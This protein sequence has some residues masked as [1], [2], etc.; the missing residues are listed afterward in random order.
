MCDRTPL[1]HSEAKS[2]LFNLLKRTFELLDLS[3]HLTE[4]D[5]LNKFLIEREQNETYPRFLSRKSC[6]LNYNIQSDLDKYLHRLST[7]CRLTKS[8]LR[9]LNAV[10][11]TSPSDYVV[12][13]D[14]IYDLIQLFQS[15]INKF[16]PADRM[17]NKRYHSQRQIH[18][19]HTIQ[20]FV[21]HPETAD[22][23]NNSH[24]TLPSNEIFLSFEK[25]SQLF[26]LLLRQLYGVHIVRNSDILQPIVINIIRL[27]VSITNQFKENLSSNHF[28]IEQ[29][30]KDSLE[31][32]EDEF[33]RLAD[34][35]RDE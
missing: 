23:Q 2:I 34:L 27:L 30:R 33:Y 1:F 25:I 14:Q 22:N 18:D 7:S 32:D 9:S 26:Q 10:R 13:D 29:P 12:I 19:S 16:Q 3:I 21:F 35:K 15:K 8:Y 20:S 11:L 6:K 28:P 31:F 17:I 5:R 24:T 4:Y